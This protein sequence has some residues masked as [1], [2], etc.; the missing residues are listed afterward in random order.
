MDVSNAASDLVHVHFGVGNR[1]KLLGFSVIAQSPMNGF[2]NVFH[3]QIEVN[4]F[5]LFAFGIEA[6]L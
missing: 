3:N 2:W 1:D 6:V 5:G 4:L